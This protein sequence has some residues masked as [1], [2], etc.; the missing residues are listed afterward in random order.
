M[1]TAL[2][3][4]LALALIPM[5]FSVSARADAEAEKY[6]DDALPMMYHTCRS[7]VDESNGDNAYVDKVVRALVAVSLYNRDIDISKFAKTDE[8]KSKL[9]DKFIAELAEGCKDDNNALLAGVIDDAVSQT[10]PAK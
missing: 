1:K 8:E 2:S 4:V 9:K 5:F 10:L 6:V 7:V 3:S